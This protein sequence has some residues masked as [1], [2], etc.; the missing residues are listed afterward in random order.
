[1][2]APSKRGKWMYIPLKTAFTCI[3]EYGFKATLE[4]KNWANSFGITI[5]PTE[6]GDHGMRACENTYVNQCL[7]LY[8]IIQ[9]P[10][11]QQ[12]NIHLYTSKDWS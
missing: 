7:K 3:E 6:M 2:K 10:L 4:P 11:R 9:K 8:I 1:M 12:K 5:E